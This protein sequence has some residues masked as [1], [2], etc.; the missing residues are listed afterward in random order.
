MVRGSKSVEKTK[1]LRDKHFR[2][3]TLLYQTRSYRLFGETTAPPVALTFS[4]GSVYLIVLE[5]TATITL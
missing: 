4:I 1:E 5:T 2:W 3:D